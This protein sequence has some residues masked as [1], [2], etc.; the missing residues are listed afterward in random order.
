MPTLEEALRT[1][2][3]T[4]VRKPK[5]ASTVPETPAEQIRAL[6]NALRELPEPTI[7]WQSLN[8]VKTAGFR[9]PPPRPSLQEIPEDSDHP[10]ALLRKLAHAIRTTEDLRAVKLFEKSALALRAIRGLTLL[11]EQVSSP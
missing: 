7:T 8:A 4:T 6:A 11:R 2:P 3:R 5:I 10:G 1:L 9:S